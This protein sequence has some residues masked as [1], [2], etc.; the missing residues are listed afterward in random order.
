MFVFDHRRVPI[1]INVRDRLTCL[2]SLVD[3]LERAGHER[4]VLLD[5]ASTYEPLLAYL[6]ACPHDVRCLG[7]NLGSRALWEAGMAP[8]GW[9]VYTDPDILPC[10][11]CPLDAVGHL[12]ELLERH[13]AFPKAALGLH[14]ENLPDDFEPKAH[15][16]ALVS[17]GRELEAGVYSSFADTTFALYRGSRFDYLS[18]R[19]AKPYRAWHEGWYAE[20]NP[21]EEDLYYLAHAKAGP[22]ASSW[23]KRARGADAT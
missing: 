22:L 6:R 14:F 15:E 4:I 13:S 10:A 3:W 19:T 17:P 16:R 21:T 18:L 9:Y 8:A 1:F 5:N 23:A 7:R 12:H 2:P 20:L 11:D